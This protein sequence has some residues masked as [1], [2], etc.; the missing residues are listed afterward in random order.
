MVNP[1]QI[2]EGTHRSLRSV[3]LLESFGREAGI[4][5]PEAHMQGKVSHYTG[6]FIPTPTHTWVFRNY[7]AMKFQ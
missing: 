6:I 1:K 4:T 7:F 3:R 5:S 2:E